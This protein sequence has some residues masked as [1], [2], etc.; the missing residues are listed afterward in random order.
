MVEGRKREGKKVNSQAPLFLLVLL[1][2]VL[3]MGDE[4]KCVCVF[5]RETERDREN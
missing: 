5:M 4:R 3:N 1:Q 2:N